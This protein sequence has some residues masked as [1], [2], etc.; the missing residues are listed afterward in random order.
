MSLQL[1]DGQRGDPSCGYEYVG[2]G[3]VVPV[4]RILDRRR[5]GEIPEIGRGMY[6]G[7]NGMTNLSVNRHE[8]TAFHVSLRNSL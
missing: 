8:R 1:T 2:P 4:R 5:H 6:V 3:V 7:Y